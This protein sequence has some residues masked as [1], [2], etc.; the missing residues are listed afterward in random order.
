MRSSQADEVLAGLRAVADGPLSAATNMPPAMYHDDEILT[1]EH[2]RVFAR[3]WVSPGLAAEIPK[4]G[5]R[6]TWSIADHPVLCVRGTDGSIR[7]FSNVCRHRMMTLVDGDGTGLRITC[8]YHAWTYDLEGHLVGTKHMEDTDGFDEAD[9]CLPEVRTEVWQ[10]WIYCT[11]NSDALPV[12]ELLAPMEEFVARYG[13]PDYVPVHRQDETWGGNWKFLVENFMEGYHLPVAHRSTLGTWMP[14]DSVVFPDRRHE[15]FTYQ[16]FE[17][18]ENARYGRAHPDNAR[19]EESWRSTTF[20]PTVFPS[21]M[22]ILAPDH[23]WYLSLRPDG[24]D[25]VDLRFGIALAPEVYASLDDPEAWITEMV[26]FFTAVCEED[27]RVVE[28]IHAGSRSPMASPGP[29]SWLEHEIHDLMGYLAD[30]LA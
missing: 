19:L 4:P 6:L 11:L 15:G 18:D 13:V 2:D 12:A 21:H 24:V 23:L 14:M 8:P 1:L 26:E 27:R 17:K 5:D 10:G 9:V 16:L 28:G 29:L 20:M 3:D 30:R 7:T 22:Y 25:R